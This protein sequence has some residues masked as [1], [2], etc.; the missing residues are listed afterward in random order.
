MTSLGQSIADE[1]V[2][3]FDFIKQGK[4]SHR[5]GIPEWTVLASIVAIDINDNNRIIP[6]TISTGTKVLPDVV[7]SYSNGYFVHDM[8]AEI[9]AIRL[10]NWYLITERDTSDLIMR[11]KLE[12]HKEDVVTSDF[13]GFVKEA[14]GV[15]NK[16]SGA[17]DFRADI[18]SSGM[19]HSVIKNDFADHE[20]KEGSSV[21]PFKRMKTEI[22]KPKVPL[23][24]LSIKYSLKSNIKLALFISEPPCGDASMRYISQDSTSWN[25][26]SNRGRNNYGELGIV[27]TKPGR[28]DSLMTLTKSCSDKLALKKLLGLNNAFTSSIFDPIY[29]D[30][31]VLREDKFVQSDIERCF[32]RLDGHKLNILSYTK[33]SYPYHKTTASPSELSIIKVIPSNKIQVLNNGVKNGSYRKKTVPKLGGEAFICN[34]SFQR[35]GF[36]FESYIGFKESNE[37]RQRLKEKGRQILGN[38]K[39]TSDDNFEGD[40]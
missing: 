25:I 14:S 11:K 24:D 19:M 30:Y 17:R 32:N 13:D 2:R 21:N 7:R 34:R 36:Q 16:T 39:R 5:N 31:L 22:P 40:T 37:N 38:W 10:L 35:L 20:N 3:Q 1:V 29:L 8:H 15:I 9:L 27:R 6:L 28:L 18:D 12:T 33:D 4:P 26:D 23:I